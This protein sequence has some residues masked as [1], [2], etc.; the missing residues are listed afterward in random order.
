MPL[1]IEQA[2][3]ERDRYSRPIIGGKTYMRTTTLAGSLEDKSGLVNW[4]RKDA[5]AAILRDPSLLK[6]GDADSIAAATQERG[7]AGYGTGVH[8]VIESLL[9]DGTIP[10]GVTPEQIADAEAGLEFLDYLG[11]KAV[12]PEVFVVNEELGAAGTLDLLAEDETG[13]LVIVD[14]KTT[15]R[16]SGWRYK[17]VSWASQTAVYSRGLPLGP[18]GVP[19]D[20]SDFGLERPIQDEAV[21]VQIHAKHAKVVGFSVDLEAGY[22]LA[23]L[24]FDLSMARREQTLEVIG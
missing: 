13:Q 3:V 15:A 6:I 22:E 5:A 8:A 20:W 1:R 2:E 12:A 23:R 10:D 9:I 17:H 7:A 19:V 21:I 4:A 24:A 11:L 18:D 16:P 14:W